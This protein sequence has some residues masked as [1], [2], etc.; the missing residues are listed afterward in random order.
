LK[1]LIIYVSIY[2]ENTQKIA[3]AM[4]EVLDSSL[5]EPEEVRLDTLSEYDLIGFG[6][7][8]YWGR[9]YKRLRNFIKELPNFQNKKAFIFGTCGHNEIPYK[10]IQKLLLKKGFNVV[11][12][13]S[14][15][16][17]NTFFL[18]RILG[19]VNK[20]RPNREDFE[21]AKKFAEGLKEK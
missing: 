15:L 8:I 16:G 11:G 14:C 9:F 19:R 6:S 3:E 18:S 20:G 17:F 1:T 13:F 7:G 12:K 10:P 4:A 5:L 21:Q 2:Q